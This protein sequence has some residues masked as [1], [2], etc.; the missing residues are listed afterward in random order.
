MEENKEVI[1][2][3]TRPSEVVFENKNG[4]P[5]KKTSWGKKYVTRRFLIISLIVAVAA[6]MALS[7]GAL[8][9]FAKNSRGGRMGMPNMGYPGSE[10]FFDRGQGG[11]SGD[12]SG[13]PFNDQ[14]GV[15]FGD[16]GNNDQAAPSEGGQS[17]SQSQPSSASIGIVIKDDSGVYVTQVTGDNAKKAGIE[18]G[19]KIV[20]IEG[21]TVE[22][23]TD[24]ISEVR[25]HRSGDTIALVIE[26]NG[27]SVNINTE[28]D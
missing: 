3:E 13:N 11:Q 27:Q 17:G 14:G 18:E 25:N 20:S 2:E 6:N 8:A 21:K 22:N 15:P 19:D 23:S 9:I 24:L 10:D 1:I 7:A 4:E 12:Q 5:E 26:R 28:L 16:S